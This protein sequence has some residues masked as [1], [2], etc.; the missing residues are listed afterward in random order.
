RRRRFVSAAVAGTRW[1]LSGLG[2]RG[3]ATAS[4]VA[5]WPQ[6][7][8]G[9]IVLPGALIVAMVGLFTFVGGYVVPALP[10]AT[11]RAFTVLHTPAGADAPRLPDRT[12]ADA[13]QQ[14]GGQSPTRPDDL[15]GWATPIAAKVNIPLP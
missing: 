10:T 4:A 5:A 12:G 9:R 3:R 1:V 11:V 7:P 2:R 15:R 8:S 6:R 13:S 14:T